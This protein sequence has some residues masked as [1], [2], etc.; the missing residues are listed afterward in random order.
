MQIGTFFTPSNVFEREFPIGW[1]GIDGDE[2]MIKEIEDVGHKQE[3]PVKDEHEIA[4]KPIVKKKRAKTM[5]HQPTK[6]HY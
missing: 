4:S 5:V 6:S 3:K 2:R 1:V